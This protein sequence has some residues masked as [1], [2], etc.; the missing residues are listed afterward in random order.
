MKKFYTKYRV[1]L[2]TLLVWIGGCQQ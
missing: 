1:L 2:I